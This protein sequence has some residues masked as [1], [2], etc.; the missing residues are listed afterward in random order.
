MYPGYK[1]NM[2]DLAASLGIHQLRRVEDGLLVRERYACM[3]DAAFSQIPGVR[4][5]PRPTD[6]LN[7]HGLHLYVLLLDLAQF[8][9][10]RN[11]IIDALLAENIGAALH[12]RALHM[13]P[14]YR[15]TFGYR[16]E[17]FPVAASVGESI[18]SLPLTPGMSE[19]DVADVIDAV[20]KVLSAYRISQ[21]SDTAFERAELLAGHG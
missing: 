17:D 7:R 13:H 15:E 3:Y 2:P 5:Q 8:R 1:Y 6:G 18:L 19:H 21:P 14:Y 11:Q 20:Q 4:L 16:P 12:Y 9:V 10:G